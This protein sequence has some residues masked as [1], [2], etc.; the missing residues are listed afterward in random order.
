M[1]KKEFEKQA[2]ALYTDIR[3]FL[4]N[5]FELLK[6][7]LSTTWQ[8]NCSNQLTESEIKQD[9]EWAW[10]AGFAKEVGDD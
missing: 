3:S 9:F 7:S 5:A 6:Q 1:N 2:E 4:D 10:D 8:M